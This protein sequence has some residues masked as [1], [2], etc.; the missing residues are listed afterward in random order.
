MKI[1]ASKIDN[2]LLAIILTCASGCAYIAA[3][4]LGEELT[5]L[6]SLIAI[7]ILFAGVV[8]PLWLLGSTRYYINE[9]KN[10]LIVTSGPFR[11][12]INI[13]S[14]TS[15]T[16]TRNPISSPAL[17][18]D[19]LVISYGNRQQLMVSPKQKHEF[20]VALAKE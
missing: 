16:E 9:Q 3:K 12:C 13:E 20:L 1:F 19:R 5:I 15:I 11:W 4:F 6:H 17:S 7:F 10:Q 14:I 2:W 18:L 8:F